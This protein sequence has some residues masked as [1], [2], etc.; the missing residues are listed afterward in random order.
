MRR[1][2]FF[3]TDLFYLTTD[4]TQTNMSKN[5]YHHTRKTFKNPKEDPK[6]QRQQEKRGHEQQLTA[7]RCEKFHKIAAMYSDSDFI[8]SA[9][10]PFGV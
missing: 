6:V 3:Y 2:D 9:D 1:N 8:P 10:Q 5:A 7:K 4:T